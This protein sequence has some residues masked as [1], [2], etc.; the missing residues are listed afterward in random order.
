MKNFNLYLLIFLIYFLT[1]IVRVIPDGFHPDSL[2]YMSMAS[3]LADG[4][5]NFWN[6]HFTDTLFNHFYEHP[7]LGIFTMAIPFYMFGDSIFIDKL[8]GVFVGILLAFL[9]AAIVGLITKVHKRNT[10]LLS[11]FYFL[12]FPIVGNSLEN[13]LLEVPAT[14]F[15]LLSLYAFLKYT[16][17]P[18]QTLSLSLG[19][20]MALLAAFLVKGPVMIFTFSLPFFY[21][22]LFYKTYSFKEMLKYYLYVLFFMTLFVFILYLYPASNN[23]LTTYF[24][25]QILSSIDGSRGGNEHFKLTQ[26]LLIDFSLIFFISL[27]VVSIGAKKFIKPQFTKYFWLFILIGL[28]GS[29]P[30]EISPRQHDYYIFPSLSFF[31]IA[32]AIIFTQ[33]ITNLIQ[34]LYSYKLIY[35]LNFLLIIAVF[36]V[37]FEKFHQNSRYKNFYE[38]FINAKVQIANNSKIKTCT[39]N[40]IDYDKFHQNIGLTANIKR[41]FNAELTESDKSASYY[42][43]SLNSLKSCQP[44]D[45]KYLYIGVKEAK[46]YLLY[47]RI[48]D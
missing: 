7:P 25:N 47:K 14:F 11:L 2:V 9:I 30:L 6:L 41:Y 20:S 22:L 28:S 23:Y 13:N 16:K 48:K 32:L 37:S 43:T 34:K 35:L 40:P 39:D 10:L 44:N 29:V 5:S 3:S 15:I 38:D 33:E 19:F 18:Q 4:T 24:T 31:A 46:Y 27:I 21:F 26:Q 42:L 45:L 12:A 8:Y 1:T 17:S 36:I